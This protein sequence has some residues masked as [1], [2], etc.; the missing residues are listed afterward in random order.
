MEAMRA[1]RDGPV[2]GRQDHPGYGQVVIELL[3]PVGTPP[4]GWCFYYCWCCWLEPSMYLAMA[5]LPSGHLKH[6]DDQ[7]RMLAA[8]K[9]VYENVL[10]FMRSV[11]DE[12]AV[13]R[14]RADPADIYESDFEHF[15]AAMGC[16]VEVGAD[17]GFAVYGSPRLVGLR[18]RRYQSRD[19]A[20]NLAWHYDTH[21]VWQQC[22][23][24]S[25]SSAGRAA[26]GTAI[27]GISVS[28]AVSIEI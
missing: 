20:G 14:L 23:E 27:S 11:G 18:V 3:D 2:P 21:R 7:K 4:D 1:G 9:A 13:R 24:A 6:R 10:A 8:A 17:A 16:S 19:G 25:A 26:G 5:R 22:G 12:E 15:A 28:Y